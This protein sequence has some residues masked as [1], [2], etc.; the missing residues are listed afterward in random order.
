MSGSQQGHRS[1]QRLGVKYEVGPMETTMEEELA[2]LL[3]IVEKA[4][5]DALTRRRMRSWLIE[6]FKHLKLP[7]CS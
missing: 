7:Y 1:D 2:D 3:A 6:V 5:L 4:S